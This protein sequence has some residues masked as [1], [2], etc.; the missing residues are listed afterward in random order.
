MRTQKL[1][2]VLLALAWAAMLGLTAPAGA[3]DL[4]VA[5]IVS[6]DQASWR[7]DRAEL[8]LIFRRQKRFRDD[9]GKLQPVNLPPADPLRRRFNDAVLQM[10]DVELQD[11]WNGMYFHG[12]KPPYVVASEEAM[13][14]VTATTEG[15]VGYVALCHADSRVAVVAVIVDGHVRAPE[16]VDRQQLC[17]AG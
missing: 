14:R 7:P 5:V 8:A 6:P 11:Y 9:G 1:H 3:V 16:T 13:L 12:I 17:A 2:R 4:P 10:S 15:V